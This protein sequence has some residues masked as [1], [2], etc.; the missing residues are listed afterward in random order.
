[1]ICSSTPSTPQDISIPSSF[2]YIKYS[3]DIKELLREKYDDYEGRQFDEDDLEAN[4]EQ[5][6]NHFTKDLLHGDNKKKIIHPM[7]VF[8]LFSSHSLESTCHY[9]AT[10]MNEAEDLVRKPSFPFF[11]VNTDFIINLL[12]YRCWVS[13]MLQW[14]LARH[15]VQTW[16]M[17]ILTM[18]LHKTVPRILSH[19]VIL[20]L[21]TDVDIILLVMSLFGLI[22]NVKMTRSTRRNQAITS[23]QSSSQS[24]QPTPAAATAAA[25]PKTTRSTA[26][27]SNS[28]A[29]TQAAGKVKSNASPAVV[30]PIAAASEKLKRKY[31]KIDP[32]Q[33]ALGGGDVSSS[34]SASAS[35]RAAQSKKKLRKTPVEEEGEMDIDEDEE[36]DEEEKEKVKPLTTRS[37][38]SA[39]STSATSKGKVAGK[40]SSSS[41]SKLPILPA[42]EKTACKSPAPAPKDKGR[43]LTDSR[44]SGK[45]VSPI[46]DIDMDMDVDD[47]IEDTSTSSSDSEQISHAMTMLKKSTKPRES[48]K[49]S[50]LP[51]KLGKSPMRS[52]TN[53]NRNVHFGV[54]MRRPWTAEEIDA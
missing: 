16:V 11:L 26:A 49:K 41:S 10:L 52:P 8:E 43:R 37:S 9:L 46:S 54:R 6:F 1:M 42:K 50:P 24:S 23:S 38:K 35:N 12:L 25:A 45:K 3:R 27:A 33:D 39:P 44:P 53:G 28:K 29:P 7:K 13:L 5:D 30:G 21:L 36:E 32:L 15:K 20:S 48:L 18:P 14:Y 22:D 4:F 47:E 31:D 17:M 2:D 51:A 19:Q 40:P 34:K